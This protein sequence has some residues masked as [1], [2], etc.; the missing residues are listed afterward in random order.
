MHPLS[1]IPETAPFTAV[2]RN[3]LNGFFAGLITTDRPTAP[4]QPL[5]DDPLA[6]QHLEE[7]LHRAEENYPW[8]DP[9]LE[10]NQRLEMA[11]G[12]PLPLRLMAAMAQLNCGQ[13]GY[14]CLSY[15]QAL[16]SRAE[17]KTSLCV[18]GG[19]PTQSIVKQMLREGGA[20]TGG[21]APGGAVPVAVPAPRAPLSPI[22]PAASAGSRENP[23]AATISRS[24]PLNGP[25][26][27]RDTRHVVVTL[28]DDSV[29]YA[30]GDSLGVYPENCPDLVAAVMVALGPA[31]AVT[32]AHAKEQLVR[33]DLHALPESLFVCLR[34]S[35]RDRKERSRLDALADGA[36]PENVLPG[37][38]DV[39]DV[40]TAF[41]SARPAPEALLAALAPLRP[42]LYSISSSPL[43]HPHEVHLTVGVVGCA[44]GNRWR[45]GVASSFLAERALGQRVSV[46]VQPAHGFSP[47]VG[48]TPAIM[49]G[50][51]TGIA[52]F[53]AFLQERQ[54]RGDRG[55]NWLFFGNP[56]ADTDFLYREEMEAW[57]ADGVLTH[58]TTAF[59]RDQ[60]EKIYVQHRIRA[61]GG[62]L[63]EWLQSGAGLYLCGDASR[64]A[65]DVDQALRDVAMAAG[66]L[67][68]DAAALWLKEM[69][70][71]GRYQKD[72]Y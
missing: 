53:R 34:D 4:A 52:P 27:E 6:P 13:C 44:V 46:F 65:R 58:L 38:A 69:S 28:A 15:G 54:A 39:L 21:G 10:L 2:Q 14:S 17:S 25:G 45:K 57:L 62:R 36:E 23:V 50:P 66:G 29:S 70:R 9:T 43:R 5:P 3:W 48:D 24:Q 42:R 60:A 16:A 56:H 51:G 40:L 30:A 8:H 41:P 63:W 18:P 32:L 59:S 35:A 12:Q 31:D 19:R 22:T 72:I 33:T 64:M 71:Q 7:P 11:S 37:L 47:P 20:S 49:I 68:A 61:E 55:R 1:L 26:S 67:G